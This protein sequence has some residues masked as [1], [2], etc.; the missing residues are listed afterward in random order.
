[1]QISR[2]DITSLMNPIGLVRSAQGFSYLPKYVPVSHQEIYQH[3]EAQFSDRV[4]SFFKNNEKI[5]FIS[6]G[7]TSKLIE[8]FA[9]MEEGTANFYHN[10]QRFLDDLM[11]RKA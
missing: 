9:S 8:T 4:D 3:I 7:E 2:T 5:D 11:M 1:M 10:I 6:V